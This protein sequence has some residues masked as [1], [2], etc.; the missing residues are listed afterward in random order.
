[1]INFLQADA[2]AAAQ[3]GGMGGFWAKI[4]DN[5]AVAFGH[6]RA[7]ARTEILT[8]RSWN[9]VCDSYNYNENIGKYR[10]IKLGTAYYE[11]QNKHRSRPSV[12]PAHKLLGNVANVAEYGSKHHASKQ[13]GKSD[14]YFSDLEL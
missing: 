2:A 6:P 7:D 14:M 1:M 13:R 5:V 3:P 12:R 8:C 9:N 11:K 4:F 10:K